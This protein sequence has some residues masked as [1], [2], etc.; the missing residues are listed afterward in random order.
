MEIDK[1]KTAIAFALFLMFAMASSLVALPAAN[2][3]KAATGLTIPTELFLTAWPNPIGV[4]QPITVSPWLGQAPIAFGNVLYG[5]NF[6]INVIKPD[7]SNVT[8]GPFESASNGGYYTTY[9]PTT[10]GNYTFQ[11]FFPETTVTVGRGFFIVYPPGTYTWNAAES[12][13]VTV[14]VL[15]TAVSA[16]PQTPLPTS[17]WQN[18]IFAENQNWYTLAGNWLLGSGGMA[19]R[20]SPADYTTGPATA[21]ILWTNPLAFGGI[22][23]GQYSSGNTAPGSK[24]AYNTTD[25]GVNYYTGQ[26]YQ[27]KLSTIIISGYMYYNTLPSGLSSTGMNC[28]NLRTGAIVWSKPDMPQ[29]TCGEVVTTQGGFG[30]GSYAYLWASNSSG[31]LMYDAFTGQLLTTFTSVPSGVSLSPTWGP[32]GEILQYIYNSGR[33]YLALWNSTKARAGG[34]GAG[35][36]YSPATTTT[37]SRGLEWNVTIPNTV[38]G[39]WQAFLDYPDGVLVAEGET[40]TATLNPTFEFY[41]YSTQTGALLWATNQTN[42]GSG[43]GGPGSNAGVYWYQT[44]ATLFGDGYFAYYQRETMQYHVLNVL[45]GKEAYVTKPLPTYTGTDLSYY[46]WADSCQIADGIMYASGYDGDITAW[47]VT[48]GEHLWTFKQVSSGL[49]TPYGTW[50]TFGGSGIVS[51]GMLYFGFTQHTPGVPLFRGYN[52]YCINYTTGAEMWEIPGFF[53]SSVLAL[54]DGVLTGYAGYD[55]QIY[56][57]GQGPSRTTVTAPSVGVT[58]STPVTISGTVTDVSAGAQQDAVARNFPNG[59]PCVSDASESAWMEY[60]YQQQ[61][62]PSTVTG[63]PVSLWVLDSNNN[64]RQ[65][66]T[67]TTNA[68]GSYGFTWTPDIS[69]NFTVYA[70]FAGSNSYYGSSA[71]TYFYAGAAPTATPPT[72]YPVPIDY[73]M[74]IVGAAIAI[75]IVV[76]VVGILILRKE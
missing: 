23:G 14:T 35:L 21:H 39:A 54:A 49:Q 29:L 32:N 50:P 36:P 53:P 6:T 73:T 44:T 33:H 40:D 72:T 47:N 65:I 57:F 56:A 17:Y 25:W 10:A 76:I 70:V 27:N 3:V 16:W 12:S 13:A 46:D 34:L 15:S 38:S 68:M 31:W 58:T 37:W 1:N 8:L 69:G 75:I 30:S 66:G 74:A 48:T 7:G 59:L 43:E 62:C 5:W 63:V 9:T 28:I 4:G 64:Y 51:N 45:T 24:T 26:L 20:G 18:P 42:V 71:S 55:N 41:G 52:L 61:P 19:G 60:V 67:T 2:V 11:A 22:S